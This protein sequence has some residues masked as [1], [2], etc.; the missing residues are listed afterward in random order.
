M[1]TIINGLVKGDNLLK[2]EN[3]PPLPEEED[4]EEAAAQ[5]FKIVSL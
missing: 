4:E 5:V 1:P 3:P 2:Y